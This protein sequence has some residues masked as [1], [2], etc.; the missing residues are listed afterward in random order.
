MK[1][2]FIKKGNRK[3]KAEE[4]GW[5]EKSLRMKELTRI[6]TGVTSVASWMFEG[7]ENGRNEALMHFI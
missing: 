6:N 7:L 5:G 1:E 4:T 2:I 3:Q